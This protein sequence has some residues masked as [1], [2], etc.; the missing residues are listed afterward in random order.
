[1]N[2]SERP[3]QLIL[4]I[5]E[6]TTSAVLSTGTSPTTKRI[7][8]LTSGI[9]LEKCEHQCRVK[10]SNPGGQVPPQGT[11]PAELHSVRFLNYVNYIFAFGAID[12]S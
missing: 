7:A 10:D 9:I 6:V 11:L 2:T 12:F 8:P 1:M 3:S 5:D 4:N